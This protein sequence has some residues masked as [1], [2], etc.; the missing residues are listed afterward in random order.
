MLQPKIADVEA[1]SDYNLKLFY[2]NGEK[3]FLTC[4]PISAVIGLDGCGMHHT[5]KLCMYS[6]TAQALHGRMDKI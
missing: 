6:L 2:V 5:S 1:L 3:N 4:N